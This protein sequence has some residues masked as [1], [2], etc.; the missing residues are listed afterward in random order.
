MF[1]AAVLLKACYSFS[2]SNFTQR[3]HLLI[4]ASR[5]AKRYSLCNSKGVDH[6]KSLLPW[7]D[8]SRQPKRCR[9][10]GH[11]SELNTTGFK[12]LP[13]PLWDEHFCCLF[14]EILVYTSISKN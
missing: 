2:N 12:F 11:S 4:K 5:S 9:T 14:L 7:S 10:L 1:V 13:R 6:Q 3:L 8:T